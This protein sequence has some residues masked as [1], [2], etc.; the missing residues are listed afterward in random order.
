MKDRYEIILSGI[1]GQG[2]VLCGNIIG[3][4]AAIYE[5]KNASMTVSHGVETRGTFSKSD[6]I[7]SDKEIY[8]P[9]VLKEDLILALAQVAYD[10]YVSTIKEDA[11]LIYDSGMVTETKKSKAKQYGYPLSEIA[12]EL[13]NIAVANIIA[14]GIIVKMTGLVKK[15]SVIKV[16]EDRFAGRE[17]IIELNKNAFMKGLELAK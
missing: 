17:K 8:Y 12:K 2:L 10:K 16:I 7:V 4:A 1:G 15:E 11:I 6:V 5:G 14:I 9:Q 13:G 3:E